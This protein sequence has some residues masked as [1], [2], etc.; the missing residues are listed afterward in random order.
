[1][2]IRAEL[3]GVLT[4][5]ALVAASALFL[6][7]VD[8]GIPGQALLQSLQLHLAIPFLGL[9]LLFALV[10][11]Y[12]RALLLVGLALF[13]AGHVALRVYAQ[14][15]ARAPFAGLERQAEFTLLS[16]NVLY[17]N[18]EPEALARY[19]TGSGA[20]V[21]VILEAAPLW[22]LRAEIDAVYPYRVGCDEALRCDLAVFSRFPL[23]NPQVRSLGELRSNRLV[24]AGVEIG[25][26]ALTLVAAHLSKPYFDREGEYEAQMLT[27]ILRQI[28]GPLVLAGDFNA[29]P[30]SN[31]VDAMVRDAGLA[32]A[33][34]HPATWPTR[35]G[36]LGIPI[37]HVLSRAPAIVE[38][39]ETTPEP[40]GSNHYGLLARIGVAATE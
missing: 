37:D 3:R 12:G 31:A 36:P 1:M 23:S 19:I 34:R 7:R 11:A 20:D 26:T 32:P 17:D 18:P 35:L 16:F 39:I 24:T 27:R 5:F 30:W 38:S 40:F 6:A 13:A 4:G 2:A 8:V 28:E 33:P 14:H 10:R 25:G 9:A 15:E 22:P 29:A 21:A